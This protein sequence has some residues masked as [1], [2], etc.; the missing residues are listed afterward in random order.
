MEH[1]R[2]IRIDGDEFAIHE[3]MTEKDIATLAALLLQLRAIR[4]LYTKDYDAK[5]YYVT[6]DGIGVSR[7]VMDVYAGESAAKTA[8]DAKNVEID[9]AKAAESDARARADDLHFSQ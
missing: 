1:L 3:S 8:R 4:C 7:C 5:V 2:V 9:A 6:D